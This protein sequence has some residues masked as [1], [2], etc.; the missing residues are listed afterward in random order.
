M[1]MLSYI[2][3]RMLFLKG[4]SFFSINQAL[5]I[6][7]QSKGWGRKLL[8]NFL[9][10]LTSKNNNYNNNLKKNQNLKPNKI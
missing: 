9:K 6:V 2:I 3:L 8:H 4:E 10:Y 5:S 7:F 1:P